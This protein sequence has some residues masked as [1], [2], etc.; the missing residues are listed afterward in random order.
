MACVGEDVC[1]CCGGEGSREGGGEDEGFEPACGGLLTAGEGAC[2]GF[3]QHGACS[4]IWWGGGG[5]DLVRGG[6]ERMLL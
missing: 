3:G 1:D 6:L 5:V 2:G 4:I